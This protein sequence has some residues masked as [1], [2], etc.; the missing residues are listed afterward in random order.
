[1]LV[2][3][4]DRTTQKRFAAGQVALIC[5]GLTSHF[6]QHVCPNLNLAPWEIRFFPSGDVPSGSRV[7]QLLDHSDQQG[8][9]GYHDEDAQGHP[10]SKIFVEDCMAAGYSINGG[11]NS[12]SVTIDHE[13]KECAFDETCTKYFDMG[14]GNEI[15][16]EV[17]D[18][19]ESQGDAI[20]VNGQKVW[21]SDFVYMSYFDVNGLGQQIFNWLGGI[22][23]PFQI[24]PGGY[25]LKRDAAGNVNPVYGDRFPD[26]KK[27][28]KEGPG[29]RLA[30]RKA[31]AK[32]PVGK[33]EDHVLPS[34]PP[35]R[36]HSAPPPPNDDTVEA[37]YTGKKV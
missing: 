28:W 33:A 8:A 4:V 27:A 18:P 31:A 22:T 32:K 14:D 5:Q 19:V 25:I 15:A 26:F 1:M 10:E 21:C 2:A 11:P 34:A 6:A 37:T 23:K 30:L 24:L 12:V 16:G 7:M 20:M 9:A 13:F 17:G 29:S 3:V 35:K 36:R